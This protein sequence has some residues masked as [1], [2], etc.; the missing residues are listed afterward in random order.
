MAKVRLATGR[1]E[2]VDS[3]GGDRGVEIGQSVLMV[4]LRSTARMSS[5]TSTP[6]KL[7]E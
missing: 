4:V 3:D 5:S 2:T 1:P 6:P 7:V